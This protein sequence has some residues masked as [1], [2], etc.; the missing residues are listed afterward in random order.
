MSPPGSFLHWRRRHKH[1]HGETFPG[2]I[3]AWS[4]GCHPCLVVPKSYGISD[5]FQACAGHRSSRAAVF[6]EEMSSVHCASLNDCECIGS[7]RPASV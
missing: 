3:G 5:R 7:G 4:G 6:I 1:N 2:R